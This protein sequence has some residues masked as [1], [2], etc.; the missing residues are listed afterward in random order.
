[1]SVLLWE[2]YIHIDDLE[3][4]QAFDNLASDVLDAFRVFRRKW[5]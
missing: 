2:R 4:L 3:A 5:G 1:M